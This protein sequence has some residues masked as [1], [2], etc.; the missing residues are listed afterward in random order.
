MARQIMVEIASKDVP[1]Y[2]DM[3]GMI[4]VI[5]VNTNGNIIPVFYEGTLAV[6]SENGLLLSWRDQMCLI[7]AEDI[8]RVFDRD[9]F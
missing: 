9:R 2:L 5:Y 8:V 3:T 4:E 7:P 6:H 1:D